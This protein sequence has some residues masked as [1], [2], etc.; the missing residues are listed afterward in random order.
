MHQQ[1]R[2]RQKYSGLAR[3]QRS[4]LLKVYLDNDDRASLRTVARELG[5][6]DSYAATLAIRQFRAIAEAEKRDPETSPAP[7][8]RLRRS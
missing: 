2:K 5:I 3:Q 6:S 7:S 1:G 8:I 4:H